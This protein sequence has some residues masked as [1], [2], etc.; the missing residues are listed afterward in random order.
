[1]YMWHEG[2]AGRGCQE[3]ASCLLK[4]I[5]SLALYVKHITAFSGNCGRQNKSH[6]TVKFWLYIVR[7]TNIETVGH[8]FLVAGHSYNECDQD[9]GLI[10][11]KRSTRPKENIHTKTLGRTY[12]VGYQEVH[13]GDDE[14]IRFYKPGRSS[15]VLQ[16]KHKRNSGYALVAL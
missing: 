9:F 10:E 3:I 13:R 14:Q 4:F 8:R 2:Q 11:K 6:L 15:I 7:N 1:M 12:G 5:K 16:E